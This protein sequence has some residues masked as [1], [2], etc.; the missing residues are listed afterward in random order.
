[1]SEGIEMIDDLMKDGD[2]MGWEVFR[3]DEEPVKSKK[4]SAIIPY[5]AIKIF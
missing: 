2:D 5:L 1:M 3:Q 4:M